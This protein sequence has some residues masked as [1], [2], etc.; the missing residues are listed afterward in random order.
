MSKFRHLGC[1]GGG[2]LQSVNLGSVGACEQNEINLSELGSGSGLRVGHP[3][4]MRAGGGRTHPSRSGAISA[5]FLSQKYGRKVAI[6]SHEH[7]KIAAER[8]LTEISTP[9]SFT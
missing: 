6:N 8:C 7:A 9:I 1:S 5:R 3:L 4:R 2:E